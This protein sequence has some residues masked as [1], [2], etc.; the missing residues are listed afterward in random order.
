MADAVGKCGTDIVGLQEMRDVGNRPDYAAQTKI[1][2]EL[3]GI[4]YYYFAE[5]VRFDGGANPYGN[6]LSPKYSILSAKPIPIPDQGEKTGTNPYE[7]C[8]V[9]KAKL[10]GEITMPVPFCIESR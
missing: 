5:T 9:L 3:M 7:R 1:L 8:C 10:E 6:G 2:S 4:K